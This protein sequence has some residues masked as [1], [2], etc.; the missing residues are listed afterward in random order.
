LTTSWDRTARVWNAE[1]GEQ[2]AVFRGHKSR[3]HTAQLSP[4][5][6]RVV[7]AAQDGTVRIWRLSPI[8]AHALPLSDPIAN[9]R[10]M[11]LS[12]DGRYLAT[13]AN[14]FFDPGPRIWDAT[15]GTLQ[16][17]LK[18]AREGILARLPSRF[19]AVSGVVFSP[20]GQRLLTIA[21]EEQITIRPSAPPSMGVLSFLAK[22]KPPPE[23]PESRSKKD[24]LLPHTPARIWDVQ[25][26]KPLAALKAGE[27]LLSCA[28]FSPDGRKVLTA[29]S[30]QKRYGIY[31]STGGIFSG[32][33]SSGG[34]W[35]T[36]VR[37]YETATGKELLK[38]PHPGDIL[39]A[40]FSADGRRILTSVN[41]GKIPNKDIQMWDAETGKLLF[42]LDK[43]SSESVA[44]FTPEGKRLVV[45]SPG[46]RLH[47][48]LTGKQLA[49]YEGMDI[50]TMNWQLRRAGISPFS[51]DGT[52]L[53]AVGRDGLGLLDIL[54]GKQLVAFRG[55]SG[56]VHSALFSPDGR[57][58]IT[59]SDDL[60]ARVWDAS[61]GEELLLLR[62]KSPVQFAA[63]TP[64]GRRVATASDTVRIWDL[65]PL[66][67]A[68]QRKARELSSEEK[69]WFG[70]K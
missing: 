64:D 18:A 19:A 4:D 38:L 66:P 39:R 5:G 3:V 34:N 70:I 33:S 20:D 67:I 32:G 15:T 28:C 23:D 51:P 2:V 6:Q 54:T 35:Q 37:V 45:F 22:P 53:L 68:L 36:F 25:T 17:N 9:F 42:A 63:M 60:T 1:S 61:T 30:T 43:N 57:F 44:C 13:G 62:H 50:W 29:D 59:A 56:A 21:E 58:V 46:I 65:Q 7:T 11:A 8:L 14:D 12:P 31:S 41:S 40:E 52:K 69:E 47:D 48:T 26:G 16:H 55:H 24:E 10:A 49:H 27:L